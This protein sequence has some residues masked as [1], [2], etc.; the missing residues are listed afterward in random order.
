MLSL[1]S[2]TSL[3]VS[4]AFGA[5]MAWSKAG[6]EIRGPRSSLPGIT[7][8]DGVMTVVAGEKLPRPEENALVIAG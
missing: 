8:T 2:S 5:V 7:P 4:G 1:K 3:S 6:S